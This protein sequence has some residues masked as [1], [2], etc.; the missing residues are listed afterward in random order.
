M[1]ATSSYCRV[2]RVV[3]LLDIAMACRGTQTVTTGHHDGPARSRRLEGEAPIASE[4]RLAAVVFCK[5]SSDSPIFASTSVA[6]ERTSQA[7]PDL[8]AQQAMAQATHLFRPCSRNPFGRSAPRQ[9]NRC[10]PLLAVK[11]ARIHDCA[12]VLYRRSWARSRSHNPSKKAVVYTLLPA[13]DG[14]SAG[15]DEG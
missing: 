14:A 6:H 3:P 2:E 5:K 12:L 7:G 4:L 15:A 13:G 9:V 10:S 11:L 8:A 1:I